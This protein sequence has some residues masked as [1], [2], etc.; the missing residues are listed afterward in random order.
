M[1]QVNMQNYASDAL[2]DAMRLAQTKALNSFSFSDC[3][4]HLNYVW[5]D[6]YQRICEIDE[7]FYSKTVRITQ[8][9]TKLPPCLKST[10]RIYAAQQPVGFNRDVFI[11]SGYNDLMS[12]STYHISGFDL[13]CPD[14]EFRTVWLN[15]IPIQ[16]QIFFTRNNRDPKLYEEFDP[17]INLDYGM[18]TLN[19]IDGSY[20]MRNK[21][22]TAAIPE[23][24]IT[25]FIFFGDDFDITYISCDYPYIFVSYRNKYTG[26][27][28]S[29]IYKDIF[30]D[31]SY[32]VYNPFDFTGRPSNVEYLKCVYNDKTGY[33]AVIRDYNDLDANGNARIKELGWTPDTLLCY[34]CP[35]M[36][37][38]LVARLADVFAAINESNVMA[39]SKELTSATYAFNAY[40]SKDKSAWK[41]IDNVTGPTITDLL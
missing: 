13:F 9:L 6:M 30:N 15:Y 39:V 20:I 19:E 12:R 26:K 14:A 24:D 21:N 36:Y 29:V 5:A 38:L 33:G 1:L 34:P 37:R 16:P 3:L 10:I 11:E 35:E 40:C 32:V 23:L 31:Q 27:Y 18:Y 22:P 41:R 8:K 7:G 2:E 28:C 25:K 17:V 4:N